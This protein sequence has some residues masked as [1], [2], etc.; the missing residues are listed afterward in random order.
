MPK[1]NDTSLEEFALPTGNFGFSAERIADLG[2][3]E[4]TL[5][6]LAIDD[7]GSVSPFK[8]DMVKC[9]KEVIKACQLSPRADFL[10]VRVVSFD[11]KLKEVHGFKLL[12]SINLDDYNNM[13]R[14]GGMTSLYD[15]STNV[16]EATSSYGQSLMENDLSVN[17]IVL[18]ITDGA[19]NT[20]IATRNSVRSALQT[21][22]TGEMLESLVSILVGVNVQDASIG[23]FLKAFKDEA[24]FTQYVELD[25]A[26]AKTLAKLADWVSKSISAQSQA[27]GTGGA[28]KSL[29]F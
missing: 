1:L 28:S 26:D 20:S 13:L 9:L 22:V 10:M 14:C 18:V 15:A 2:A 17:G 16:V 29:S 11:D 4:Y 25:K 21:A 23:G 27:L 6:S 8:D 5:V 7:S 24:G 12:S 3:T 19:D